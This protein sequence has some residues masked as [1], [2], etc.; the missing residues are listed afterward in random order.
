MGVKPTE[1]VGAHE[2]GVLFGGVSRQ[3]VYQLTCRPDFPAP[4]ARLAN[5][6]LW[7]R[8]AVKAWMRSH[9]P[10]PA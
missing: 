7:D 6:K 3:R 9:R 10:G 2:V 1:L 8:K 4:V 5:G